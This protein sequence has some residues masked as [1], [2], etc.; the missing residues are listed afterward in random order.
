MRRR[1]TDGVEADEEMR[2]GGERAGRRTCEHE[3]AD[4]GEE[5]REK[6]GEGESTAQCEVEQLQT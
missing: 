1:W 4:R 2:R 6:G 3:H 5:T